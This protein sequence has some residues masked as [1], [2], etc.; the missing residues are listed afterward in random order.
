MEL[1]RIGQMRQMLV[2]R[3]A[4]SPTRGAAA[5]PRPARQKSTPCTRLAV[6]RSR[7]DHLVVDAD[8]FEDLRPLYDCSVEMPILAITLSMPLATPLR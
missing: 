5:S 2:G 3:A 6:P 4:D 7:F 8:R 1:A